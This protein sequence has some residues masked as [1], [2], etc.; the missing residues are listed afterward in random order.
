M[1]FNFRKIASVVASA[2]MIGSTIGVAAAANYPAPFVSGG[3]ADVAIVYGSSAA[4]SDLSAAIKVQTN[5][6]GGVSS[7]SSSTSATTSGGDSTSLAS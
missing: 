3:A 1:R 7:S 4:V 5:L 2:A 6:Q